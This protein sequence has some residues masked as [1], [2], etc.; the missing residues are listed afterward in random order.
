[1]IIIVTVNYVQIVGHIFIKLYITIIIRMLNIVAILN[2]KQKMIL[3]HMM[4]IN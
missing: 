4:N 2:I 1:M 3:I